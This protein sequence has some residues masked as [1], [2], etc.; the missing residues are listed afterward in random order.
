MGVQC[1][2]VPIVRETGD[3]TSTAVEKTEACI[4]RLARPAEDVVASALRGLGCQYYRAVTREPESN[5]SCL[6]ASG[7]DAGGGR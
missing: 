2:Y 7:L 5:L 3:S 6:L 1:P 4:G